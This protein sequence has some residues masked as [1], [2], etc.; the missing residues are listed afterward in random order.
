MAELRQQRLD[1]KRKAA[2]VGWREGGGEGER[3][4]AAVRDWSRWD[5]D[6]PAVMVGRD[7]G[8]VGLSSAT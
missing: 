4:A 8:C 7:N 5:S 2:P 3:E 1:G 6:R